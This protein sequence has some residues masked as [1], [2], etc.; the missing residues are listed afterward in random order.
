MALGVADIKDETTAI[1]LLSVGVAFSG[2]AI[3]GMSASIE[4]LL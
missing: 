4:S 3:S 2:I 1:V